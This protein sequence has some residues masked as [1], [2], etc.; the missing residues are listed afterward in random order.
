[1]ASTRPACA[2]EMTSDVPESPRATRPRR[3]ASQP[4]PSSVVITSRPRIS[5]CPSRFTPTAMTT[6]TLMIRPPSRTFWVSASIHTY[7]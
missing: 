2:S 3:N 7:V 5:R 4:A 1:M 6:A